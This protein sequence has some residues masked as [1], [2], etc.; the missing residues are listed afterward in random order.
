MLI[1]D[2][3]FKKKKNKEKTKSIQFFSSYKPFSS[4]W[5]RH[6]VGTVH[7]GHADVI[8]KISRS[9]SL[10]GLIVSFLPGIMA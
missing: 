5:N 7:E 10:L 8:F 9:F 4:L 3:L 2:T 6:A 1:V